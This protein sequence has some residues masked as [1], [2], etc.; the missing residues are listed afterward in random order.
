MITDPTSVGVGEEPVK[1]TPE[2]RIRVFTDQLIQLIA[3]TGDQP[4]REIWSAML[5][6]LMN[7]ACGLPEE[8]ESIRLGLGQHAGD[9]GISR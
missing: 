3:A 1:G 7:G 4:P 5:G 9:R 2:T 6:L 8:R